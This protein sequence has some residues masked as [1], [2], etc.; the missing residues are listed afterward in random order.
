MASRTGVGRNAVNRRSASVERGGIRSLL[1]TG[2]ERAAYAVEL[3]LLRAANLVREAAQEAGLS[4]AEIAARI[5]K[6]PGFV[7]QCLTG[8]RNVTLRTLAELLA[9]LDLQIGEFRLTRLGATSMHGR[10]VRK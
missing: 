1:A 10:A 5:G 3:T 7:S 9:A 8:R 4:H 6:T 2:S